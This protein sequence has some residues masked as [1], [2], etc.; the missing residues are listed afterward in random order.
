ME[1][2]SSSH[3]VTYGKAMKFLGFR[4][5]QVVLVMKFIETTEE[6]IQIQ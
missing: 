6:V 3:I 1:P 2:E 4:L 5:D